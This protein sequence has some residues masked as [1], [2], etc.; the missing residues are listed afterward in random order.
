MPSFFDRHPR[1]TH[2]L[3]LLI[4]TVMITVVVAIKEKDI[5]TTSGAQ[6]L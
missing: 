1:L 4:L 3:G 5:A 6:N 2:F